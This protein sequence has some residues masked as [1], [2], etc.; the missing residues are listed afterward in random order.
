MQHVEGRSGAHERTLAF[1]ATLFDASDAS[2]NP[3]EWCRLDSRLAKKDA[4]AGRLDRAADVQAAT[5][6]RDLSANAA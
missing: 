6:Q 5:N 4:G 1:P 2:E 3:K